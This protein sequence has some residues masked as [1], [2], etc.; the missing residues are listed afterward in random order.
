[1]YLPLFSNLQSKQISQKV[2]N[3]QNDNS[4]TY[5]SDSASDTIFAAAC[6]AHVTS[7][8]HILFNRIHTGKL[9]L[10]QKWAVV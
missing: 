5:C 7:C 3:T 8:C 6:A 2:S 10:E 9:F 4:N 1:M